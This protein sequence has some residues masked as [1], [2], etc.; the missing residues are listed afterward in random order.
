MYAR[1]SIL[2]FFTN[3][4][5]ASPQVRGNAVMESRSPVPN[6]RSFISKV[7]VL[8]R[9]RLFRKQTNGAP[10]FRNRTLFLTISQ[11]VQ[12]NSNRRL[13]NCQLRTFRPLH[14]LLQ[15]Q[16][17]SRLLKPYLNHSSGYQLIKTRVFCS[18]F[19]PLLK[20]SIATI[21]IASPRI[22]PS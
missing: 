3:C 4:N 8:R 11:L 9:H 13:M 5:P 17:I 12:K 1:V 20:Q 6:A 18:Q 14:F 21:R 2:Q 10:S 15:V 7:F 22:Y 19:L 16:C